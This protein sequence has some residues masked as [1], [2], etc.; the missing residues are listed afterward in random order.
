MKVGK[1][2][3]PITFNDNGACL[4]FCC[5]GSECWMSTNDI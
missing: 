1:I 4:V 5:W 2:P 3:K